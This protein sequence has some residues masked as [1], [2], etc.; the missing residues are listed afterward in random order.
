MEVPTLRAY[1]QPDYQ[2][3]TDSFEKWG[4]KFLLDIN[5]RLVPLHKL[6]L[7]IQRWNV[8]THILPFQQR[9]LEQILSIIYERRD[10]IEIVAK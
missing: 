5:G 8:E 1:P 2:L 9:D 10:I 6:R 4:L 7:H 3:E